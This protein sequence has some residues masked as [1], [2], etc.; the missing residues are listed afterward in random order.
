MVTQYRVQLCLKWLS[1]T[2]VPAVLSLSVQCF[3]ILDFALALDM[4]WGTLIPI[5]DNIFFLEI[6]LFISMC[7]I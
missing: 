1:G 2:P 5:R 6:G 4:E 3:Q 7:V